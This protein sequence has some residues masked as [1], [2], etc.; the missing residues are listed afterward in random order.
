MRLNQGYRYRHILP[1]EAA[2]HSFLSYLVTNFPH[3]TQQ[4]WQAR[5][6]ANEIELD[7]KPASGAEQLKPGQL[8]I[9]NRPPWLEEFTPQCFG[10]IYQ[11]DHLLVVDKPSGLP[12]LPGA[13]F[14][15]NTLL[16]MVRAN[17]PTAKP[18]HR[19]GRAT[20]GLVL[21]ALNPKAASVL[22]SNWS[23]IQKQYLALSSQV[24][25][26]DTYD[27]Q[28]PIG[29]C[30]HPRLGKVHAANLN[31][32]K[33]RSV[34]QVIERRPTTTL[35]EVD[36]HTGRPHQI[37]IHLASIGHPLE[38]DP[39]YAIGGQPKPDHPAL[40]GDSGY[41]LH[42]KRLQFEHPITGKP[43]EINSLTP[44]ILQPK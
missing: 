14:Y 40:P 38:G 10:V 30:D 34:A 17:Y 21:F 15:L 37:R 36:L 26:Q 2:S 25:V 6:Q 5:F 24:A 23:K 11:D 9:W 3:S 41:W 16:E 28:T 31:G 19:L 29:L 22:Q 43:L 20:S 7:H 18:L 4:E 27:I 44:E 35:F 39:L 13:G 8:L 1:P 12:T 33:A 42:A 32:K